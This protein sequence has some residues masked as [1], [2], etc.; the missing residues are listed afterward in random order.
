MNCGKTE[1]CARGQHTVHG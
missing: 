1:D